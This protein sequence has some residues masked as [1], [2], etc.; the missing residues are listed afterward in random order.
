MIFGQ[1]SPEIKVDGTLSD[2]GL[3]FLSAATPAYFNVPEGVS[4]FHLSLEATP[5]GETAMASL[6]APGGQLKAEFD[7][8]SVSVDRKK[9]AVTPGTAGWWKLRVKRAPTGVLDDVWIKAG[10]ELGGYFSLT[11]EQALRVEAAR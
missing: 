2:Q 11:P 10:E 1:S 9:I 6:F 3:H 8:T 5:P 4:A 7:C